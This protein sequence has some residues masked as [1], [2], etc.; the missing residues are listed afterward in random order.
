MVVG[1]SCRSLEVLS[2]L[3]MAQVH[4]HFDAGKSQV[5]ICVVGLASVSAAL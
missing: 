1:L 3:A 4:M 2:G 5:Q